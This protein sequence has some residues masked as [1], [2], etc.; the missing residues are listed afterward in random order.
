MTDP[1][2]THTTGLQSPVRHAVAVTPD[3]AADLAVP[4]RALNVAQ[5]G[6]VRV[7]TLGGDTV[8]LFVNAGGLLPVR[9]ARVWAT[10]TT[11][12]GIVA[13]H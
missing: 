2:K 7:T 6:F 12:T 1:F 8:V 5:S 11:A 9:V 13:L 4:C 3:D 10:D